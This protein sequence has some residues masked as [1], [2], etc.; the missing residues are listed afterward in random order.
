ME[1][2]LKKTTINLSV[3]NQIT[4]AAVLDFKLYKPLGFCVVKA[5]KWIVLYNEET[6][7]I[8]KIPMFNLEVESDNSFLIKCSSRTPTTVS[9]DN[10]NER[11]ELMIAMSDAKT[12]AIELGQFFI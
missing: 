3:F 5:Y 12:K 7:Q 8:R 2:I 4:V 1:V 10:S 9:V 6:N 11:D